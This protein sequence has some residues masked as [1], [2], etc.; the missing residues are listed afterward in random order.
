M[1]NKFPLCDKKR[2]NR[3]LTLI[4][5][6]M[7]VTLMGVVA[8]IIAMMF[9]HGFDSYKSNY[10]VIKQE[11][12]VSN[13]THMLRNDI[14]YAAEI[15][16]YSGNKKMGIKFPALTPPKADKIWL[17]DTAD[18]TIKVGS[19]VIVKD[20]DAANSKF[21]YI[22]SGVNGHGTIV[23]TIQPK[24]LNDKKNANRNFLNPIIT[25][26]S[27]RYKTVNSVP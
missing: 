23:L 21:E 10:N 2:K 3:G 4:E 16:L 20:I 26:I 6:L 27:V 25:E 17:I 11:D 9:M 14:E 24:K 13:S 18:N 19:N 12:M 1:K 5:L 7:Y 8:P 22:P 15:N